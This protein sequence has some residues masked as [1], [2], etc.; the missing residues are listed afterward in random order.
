MYL[1]NFASILYLQTYFVCRSLGQNFVVKEKVL[2]KIVQYSGMCTCLYSPHVFTNTTERTDIKEGD[3]VLE[4]GSG[5]GNLTRSMLKSGAKVTAVEKDDRLFKSLSEELQNEPLELIHDDVIR[6][7]DSGKYEDKVFSK[8]V[9]NLP[10]NITTEVLKFFL[11]LGSNFQDVYLLLQDEAAQRLVQ[12]KPGD[13][14]YRAMNVLIQLCATSQYLFEIDRS[15]FFPPPNVDGAL[16]HFQLKP[17]DEILP[18]GISYKQFE[19][20]VNQCFSRRR[21]MV[22]NNMVPLYEEP[23]VSNSLEYANLK[24]DVRPQE[25][26]P[27]DYV[28]VLKYLKQQ[29]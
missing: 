4:I 13:S 11:P 7:L 25:M 1:Q 28:N 15:A 10:F 14:N 27:E 22:K 2:N 3:H 29:S 9:A 20:F 21:K 26:S 18:E 17:S 12:T 19:S 16:V 24:A 5:T 23:H 8:V 6:W